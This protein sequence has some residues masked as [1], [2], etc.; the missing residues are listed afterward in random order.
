LVKSGKKL[1][2]VTARIANDSMTAMSIQ[3]SFSKSPGIP[4]HLPQIGNNELSQILAT[5][6][7]GDG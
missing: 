2:V 6:W 1:P 7:E 5:G 3:R 4:D